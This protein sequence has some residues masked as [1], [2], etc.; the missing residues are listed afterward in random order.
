MADKNLEKYQQEQ[1]K[2]KDE[3]ER[4]HGKTVEQ[5]YKER[6]KRAKDVTELRVP[7]RVPLSINADPA[8]YTEIHRS[9]AYYDPIGWKRAVREVTVAFEPDMA[10]AGLPMS[11]AALSTLGVTN[12]LWPGGP[13]P[14]DYEYQVEEK[15][16]LKEE[17]YDIFLN[18]PTDFVLRFYLPRMYASLAP[19]AKLPPLGGMFQ[20][21]EGITPL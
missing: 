5:L 1:K 17:E 11:G 2:I 19:L 21:F 4:K 15:E 18:D 16:F 7:D 10:N 8:N 6:E 3:I 13:L 14:E 20:G 12:R 9:A